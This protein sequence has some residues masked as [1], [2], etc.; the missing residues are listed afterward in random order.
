MGQAFAVR[1]DLDEWI[2]PQE[3]R[4][5]G[6]GTWVLAR[7]RGTELPLALVWPDGSTPPRTPTSGWQGVATVVGYDERTG[8]VVMH[9][10]NR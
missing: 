6:T 9:V 8:R 1:A 10:A 7:H 2:N 4:G 5:S 3:T